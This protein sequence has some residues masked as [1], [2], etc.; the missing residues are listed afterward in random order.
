MFGGERLRFPQKVRCNGLTGKHAANDI[1]GDDPLRVLRGRQ[2]GVRRSRAGVRRERLKKRC[3]PQI[4]GVAQP[5]QVRVGAPRFVGCAFA[6]H[7]IGRVVADGLDAPHR[8]CQRRQIVVDR[9]VEEGELPFPLGAVPAL[10]V[11]RQFAVIADDRRKGVIGQ[12]LAQ[13]FQIENPHQRVAAFD[14][15]VEKGERLP[16]S[17]R[18][19]PERH[20]RQFDRQRVPVNAVDAVRNHVADRLAHPLRGG[21]V[22]AGA[23]A[24]QF[25][26]QATGGRQQKMAAAA[27]R[28]EHVEREQRCFLFLRRPTRA[29]TFLQHRRQRALHQFVH[30]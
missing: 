19:E 15:M 1:G 10:E 5:A 14:P 29:H 23:N 21:F 13:R 30:Q 11:C 25:F 3:R 4:A 26:P 2:G 17:V 12:P 28:I 8:L 6:M 18:F 24:R 16:L 20:P 9:R 7:L 27:R 22:F